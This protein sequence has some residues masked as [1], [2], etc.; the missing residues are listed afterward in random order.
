MKK[1]TMSAIVAMLV[2]VLAAMILIFEYIKS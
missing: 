2:L 1:Q